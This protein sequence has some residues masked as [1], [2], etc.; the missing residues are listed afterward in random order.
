V[1]LERSSEGAI[2]PH[3][4]MLSWIAAYEIKKSWSPIWTA[5]K[6]ELSAILDQLRAW[7]T[8]SQSS[9]P[10]GPNAYT[11]LLIGYGILATTNKEIDRVQN[12]GYAVFHK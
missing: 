3:F 5:V 4:S 9:Q 2:N 10:H 12:L 1:P 8:G 7:Q 6:G 11:D